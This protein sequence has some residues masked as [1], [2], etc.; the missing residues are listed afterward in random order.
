MI[1]PGRGVADRPARTERPD[2]PRGGIGLAILL[3][4]VLW[5]LA[6]VAVLHLA[7][8]AWA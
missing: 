5:A 8:V 1:R 6:V 7:A 2:A 3:S 4:V